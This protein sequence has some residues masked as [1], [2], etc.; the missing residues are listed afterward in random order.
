MTEKFQFDRLVIDKNLI[1]IINYGF[2]LTVFKAGNLESSRPILFS[3]EVR[4]LTPTVVYLPNKKVIWLMGGY[5]EQYN[6]EV[7]TSSTAF[8][9]L[10]LD[11]FNNNGPELPLP[12]VHHCAVAFNNET[13]VFIFG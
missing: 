13:K 4:R 1:V 7:V 9:S 5:R 8:I 6:E 3:N 12:L 11:E 2:R 10:S